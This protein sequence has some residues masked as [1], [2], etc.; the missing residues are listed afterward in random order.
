MTTKIKRLLSVAVLALV[1]CGVAAGS[2]S[3]AEP[4]F[5]VEN[6]KHEVSVL[7]EGLTRNVTVTLPAA[8]EMHIPALGLSIYCTKA[9]GSGTV[10][11]KYVSGS[12]QARLES[13]V[14]SF[15][16]C[17]VVE[18]SEKISSCYVNGAISGAGKITTNA[19]DVKFGYQPGSSGENVE[20]LLAAEGAEALVTTIKISECALEGSY[21]IKGDLVAGF[22]PTN[23]LLEKTVQGVTALEGI[24]EYKTVEFPAATSE[25]LLEGQELK[26]GA[27]PA[28]IEGALEFAAP[29]GE[30]LGVFA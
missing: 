16:G 30:A 20:A 17:G 3:A 13:G 7:A 1:V 4:Y 12:P 28:S 25:K 21:K 19:L 24:Q 26:F 18:A 8:G 23:T 2:A 5:K 9:S 6:T 22:G 15:E 14:V 10:Y 29:S 11:N 27:H